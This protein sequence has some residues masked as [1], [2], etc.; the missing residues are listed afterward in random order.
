M[1]TTPLQDVHA[2]AVAVGATMFE[3]DRASQALGMT[4]DSISPGQAKMSMRVRGDMLNG[5]GTCHGGFIFTLADSTFAFA[6]NSRNLVT[7]AAGAHIE[8][9]R[10]VHE[11]DVLS[12]SAQEVA[13]AGRS[14]VYDISV[15]NQHGEIVATFRGKSARIN[16]EIINATTPA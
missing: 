2:V 13:L 12:A 6:C 10:P 1:T 3:N 15:A 7:V 16:G 5:H 8:F 9:L 14:G 4:L 11:N